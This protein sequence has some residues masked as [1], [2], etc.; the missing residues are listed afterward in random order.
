MQKK[1]KISIAICK[2]KTSHAQLE[3]TFVHKYLCSSYTFAPNRVPEE[4]TS[5]ILLLLL[6]PLPLSLPSLHHPP[7]AP[8][9]PLQ[10]F[11]HSIIQ[12]FMVYCAKLSQ[13][14]KMQESLLVSGCFLNLSRFIYFII[15]TKRKHE[16]DYFFYMYDLKHTGP[17]W[18]LWYRHPCVSLPR[19]YFGISVPMTL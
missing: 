13:I 6:L 5:L 3:V 15:Q 1:E 12:C 14:L 11:V 8:F 9:P 19:K 17:F 18:L 16:S 7:P 4:N 10:L 2:Q